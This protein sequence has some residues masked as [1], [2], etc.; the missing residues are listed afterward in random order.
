MSRMPAGG[1]TKSTSAAKKVVEPML[2][3]D[4]P[5]Y[6]RREATQAATEQRKSV[7]RSLPLKWSS[8]EGRV[9][10][11][12]GACFCVAPLL[13]PL[14]ADTSADIAAGRQLSIRAYKYIQVRDAGTGVLGEG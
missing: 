6:I 10:F 3:S 4:G 5:M 13:A 7:L 9:F 14:S 11:F 2:C 8:H 12:L 1:V